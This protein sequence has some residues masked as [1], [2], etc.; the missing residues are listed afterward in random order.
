MPRTLSESK[1]ISIDLYMVVPVSRKYVI[2]IIIWI[3]FSTFMVAQ[4]VPLTGPHI[5]DALSFAG[6]SSGWFVD[7]ATGRLGV[8]LPLGAVPGEIPIPVTFRF[9]GSPTTRLNSISE[10]VKGPG[11]PP[12]I[13]NTTWTSPMQGGIDFG[14]DY[15]IEDG[16]YLWDLAT[17]TSSGTLAAPQ[18]F[19]LGAKTWSQVSVTPDQTRI[20][21]GATTTDLGQWASQV[22]SLAPQGFTAS[23]AYSIIMDRDRARISLYLPELGSTMPILWVDRFSHCVSFQWK[24]GQAADGS[25]VYCVQI[26]NQHGLGVQVQ[27]DQ[28]TSTVAVPLCRVDFIGF[29]APAVQITGICSLASSPI[30]KISGAPAFLPS[31]IT[32][33]NPAAFDMAPPAWISAGL[34]IPVQAGT[35][36]WAVLQTM[37][38]G[39]TAGN[40]LLN[41]YTDPVG[42]S[43]EFGYSTYTFYSGTLATSS[44]GATTNTVQAVTCANSTDAGTGVTLSRSWTRVIPVFNAI[45]DSWTQPDWTTTQVQGYSTGVAT[46]VPSETWTFASGTTAIHYGNGALMEDRVFTSSQTWCDTTYTMGAAGNG[47][48]RGMD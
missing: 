26:M 38:F 2:Q 24:K 44:T 18:Q 45:T 35:D 4:P 34:P 14:H 25:T 30:W 12:T 28:S 8:N 13:L 40:A 47:V 15:T 29:Q 10:L 9:V 19:G 3:F 37:S 33:D 43:T 42:V 23:S 1:K 31:Q 11:Y 5:L 17:G 36:L 46:S 16:S 21:Y 39:Y 20:M 41:T 6:A 48:L 22:A 27:W 7:P 32:V